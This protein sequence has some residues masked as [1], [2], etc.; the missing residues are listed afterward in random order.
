MGASPGRVILG[1]MALRPAATLL[2]LCLVGCAVS[3]TAAGQGAEI[4]LELVAARLDNPLYVTHA[5]D[6]RLFVVEQPG[7]IRIV[8]SG[9]VL[10]A[11]FLD[12]SRRVAFGG[13][14]GLLGLAFH[15]D[16]R[17]NGRFFVNYT[18]DPDGATVI[19]EYHAS[20]DPDRAAPAEK[21]LLLVPQPYPNHNGGMVE[22]GPDGLLYLGLGDGGSGGDPGNRAQNTYELLGKILRIDVDRGAPYRIPPDN[23]FAAGGGRAEVFAWGLRNPWRFSFDR[24]TGA[25]WVGD[26]GQDAWEEVDVV[27]RGGNYGWR[28]MEGRHCFRPPRGCE[29]RGLEPPVA[30]YAH[31]GGRCSVIGGYVYHGR[32]VPRLAG[33][34]VSGDYCS[35]EIFGLTNGAP[36]VLLATHQWISSFGEDRAGELYVVDL[37]GSVHRIVAPDRTA[38][39][40]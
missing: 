14:R 35:G 24:E 26:V 4:G 18:R 19:A 37:K 23:P 39:D 21:L 29:T 15:P 6:D 33:T 2:A 30:E 27:R 7:R 16:Y 25:L 12:I 22:F 5:G 17:R 3:R 36:R 34:Y 10:P 32:R 28:V 1:V 9:R 40:R 8:E 11:P 38:N 13:E 20:A 31:S